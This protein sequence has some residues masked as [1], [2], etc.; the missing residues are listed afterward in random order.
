MS[1]IQ[2][3]HEDHLDVESKIE[4]FVHCKQCVAE[5]RAGKAP[6]ESPA[7]YA[8]LNVGITSDGIQVWCNRH[9]INVDLITTKLAEE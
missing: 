4:M 2:Y 6:G 5:W 3:V 7:S 9:D 1:R 8:R